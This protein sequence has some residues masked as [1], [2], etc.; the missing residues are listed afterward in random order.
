M[1][2]STWKGGVF[3]AFG[4]ASYGMLTTFVTIANG[5]GYTTFEISFAQYL[6]GFLGLWVMDFLLRRKK[7]REIRKKPTSK[8]LRNLILAGSTLGF[9]SLIYYF[10][11]QF[12]SVSIAIVLLMQSVWISVVLDAVVNKT[13]PGKLKLI[14]VAVVLIGTV[15]ATNLLFDDINT[16]WRGF[17]LGF[18]AAIS[19]SITIFSTNSVAVDLSSITRSKW[20]AF[21]ALAIVSLISIPFMISTFHPEV[22]AKW[23]II[24]GIFGTILPPI[25]LNSGMPKINLGIGAIITAIEL[26]VAVFMAYFLLNEQ[27]N[28]YQG[29]GI[30]LI[31]LAIV[32]MNYK[33]IKPTK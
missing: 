20:M 10:S 27:V 17:A 2:N 33:K 32:G 26:P 18:L 7:N 4:A 9:T 11:V 12:I 22:F 15:L 31:L 16:D 19:Y 8:N 28:L 30:V 13:K 25:L 3:V 5:E 6:L 24:L 21:G 14:A 29:L 23:G 1:K